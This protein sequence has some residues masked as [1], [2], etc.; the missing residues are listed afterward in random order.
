MK[1]M[2]KAMLRDYETG[3]NMLSHLIGHCL[4]QVDEDPG[5]LAALIS[6][7]LSDHIEKVDGM[8]CPAMV[9]GVVVSV[10]HHVAQDEVLI[11]HRT[12]AANQ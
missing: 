7:W 10:R 11:V 8:I 1:C 6:P 4:E 5:E 3:I 12:W 2:P 9:R